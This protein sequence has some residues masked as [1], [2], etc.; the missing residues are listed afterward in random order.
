MAVSTSYIAVGTA[1]KKI[2]IFDKRKLDFPF[3]EK[4]QPNCDQIRSL[5]FIKDDEALATGT[6]TSRIYIDNIKNTKESYSYL[7]HKK[8]IEGKEALFAINAVTAHPIYHT[9][10]S[11]GSD[12]SVS[13]W[14]IDNQ[15]RVSYIPLTTSV[16]SLCFSENGN[17]IGIAS[18]YNRDNGI[19]ENSYYHKIIIRSLTENELK[20]KE[21]AA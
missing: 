18:S 2:H 10:G 3:Y 4:L 17:Y 14:D 15:K 9:L 16:S 7:C 5:C 19:R 11:G 8:L 1:D 12:A 20:F 13:I 21:K 6:T